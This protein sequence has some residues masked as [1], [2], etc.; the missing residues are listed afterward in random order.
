MSIDIGKKIKALRL[1]KGMTQEELANKLGMT[2]QAVSKWENGVTAP[3]IQLLPD[4]S[5]IFGVTIDELFALTDDVHF[6]RIENMMYNERFIPKDDYAY[7]E[8]F[9]KEK[10]NDSRKKSECLTL[11]AMLHNQRAKEHHEIAAEYARDG[12]KL[13]PEKK[14]NHCALR[15]AENGIN[16]DWNFSNH[17][18]LIDYYKEF[19]KINPGYH[20]GYL[21]LMD[22]LIEDGRCHEAREVL[23]AMN[24]I[25]PSFLYQLYD[26]MIC[27]EECNLPQALKLW[28]EMTQLYPD[29]WMAWFSKGD[30]MARLCRYEEAIEYYSRAYELQPSPKYTD[31]LEAISHIYEIQGKYDDAAQ[32]L[33]EIIVLLKKDWNVTEGETVDFYKREID[34]LMRK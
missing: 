25:H 31:S 9:L 7:A 6:E 33:G 17:H 34:R 24:K 26:G 16:V 22:L 14:A 30:C 3:D 15:D 8:N 4:L 20:R 29:E 2:S 13:S 18:K 5:V 12:L 10:L 19:V 11:L 27:K 28:E 1:Q 23:E 21:W 32:K